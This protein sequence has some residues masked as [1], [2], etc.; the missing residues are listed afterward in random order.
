MKKF[1]FPAIFVFTMLMLVQSCEN[2]KAYGPEVPASLLPNVKVNIHRYGQA[3]FSLDTLHFKAGLIKLKK[4]FPYFLDADLNDTANLN[5]LFNYV[6]DT[7]IIHIYHRTMKVF[8]KVNHLEQA[9][10]SAFS[11]L[12]YYFPKYQLP[13]V[14]TYV[15]DLYYEQPIIRRDSVLVIALDD[16]LGKDFL[17]YSWLNIPLYHRRCMQKAFIPVDVVRAIYNHNFKPPYHSGTLLDRM[18]ELGKRLYF[19]DAM[20]P[21]VPDSLKICYTSR[22]MNWIEKYKRDVWA[23]LIKNSLLYST[24]YMMINKMSQP[25]PFSD[26]FSRNSPPAMAKWFGWQIVREFMVKHPKTTLLQLLKMKD[27]QAILQE[28]GYKP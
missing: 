5:Q 15:S 6:T 17:P 14:Y 8:P 9:L 16:Y 7:E 26:G 22:Q 21:K 10:G 27:S 12:K 4:S 20:L 2:Q 18:I 13:G 19:L 28:S 24:N 3:L 23:A 1:V 25:G 11:H